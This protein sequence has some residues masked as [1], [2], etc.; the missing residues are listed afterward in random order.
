[1]ALEG[2][3]KDL[4]FLLLACVTVDRPLYVLQAVVLRLNAVSHVS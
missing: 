4:E 2:P 1:M 3:S